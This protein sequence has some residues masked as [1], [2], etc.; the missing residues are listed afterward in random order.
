MITEGHTELRKPPDIMV[1]N[2]LVLEGLHSH[3][4]VLRENIYQNLDDDWGT[5]M[6]QERNLHFFSKTNISGIEH[7]NAGDST[8]INRF[9]P[10][11]II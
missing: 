2:G 11:T 4:A 1:M 5:P 9:E 6:T 3:G 8:K 10:T 7:V